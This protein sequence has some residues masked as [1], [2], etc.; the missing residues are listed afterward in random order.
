MIEAR[1]YHTRETLKNGMQMTVRA[2]RQH[3]ADG[4]MHV[5]LALDR[6]QP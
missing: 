6:D 3:Y 5:T 1:N 4:L 2:I